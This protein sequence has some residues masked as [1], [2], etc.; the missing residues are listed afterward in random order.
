MNLYVDNEFPIRGNSKRP[1]ELVPFPKFFGIKCDP[2][3]QDWKQHFERRKELMSKHAGFFLVAVSSLTKDLTSF[4]RVVPEQSFQENYTGKFQF[5]FY[6]DDGVLIKVEIDD[7]LPVDCEGSLQYAQAVGGA[8]WYPLLEKAYAKFRGNYE[9]IEYGLPFESFFHLT[10][11]KS[12][13]FDNGSGTSL[14]YT[15]HGM[16]SKLKELVDGKRLLICKLT[17]PRDNNQHYG[18]GFIIV[19]V[20]EKR[21]MSNDGISEPCTFVKLRHPRGIIER[22]LADSMG[23][24]EIDFSG[25]GLL[26]LE[27][28]VHQMQCV[29]FVDTSLQELS[30]NPGLDG[31][32]PFI[33]LKPDS[34]ANRHRCRK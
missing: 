5:N 32:L 4:H 8:F 17:D 6:K 19:D 27:K 15:A 16:Y 11:K 25:E 29:Y 33:P 14:P 20:I 23:I 24:S 28:F 26:D 21:R 34:P 9:I 31:F 22:N 7:R 13:F 12:E 10:R 30:L 1:H 3:E 18:S 2:Y